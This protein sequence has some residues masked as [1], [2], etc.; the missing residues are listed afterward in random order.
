MS[1]NYAGAL[2]NYTINYVLNPGLRGGEY[3][4]LD[5]PA[6]IDVGTITNEGASYASSA[7][8]SGQTYIMSYSSTSSD[9][10]S[11]YIKLEI[12]NPV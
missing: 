9:Q 5:F 2:S 8:V 3:I 12:T 7:G 11:V 10:V 1:N 4:Y 6:D